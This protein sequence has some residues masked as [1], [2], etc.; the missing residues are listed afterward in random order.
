MIN[1]KNTNSDYFKEKDEYEDDE[2]ISIIENM[3]CD[4]HVKDERIEELEERIK[5]LTNPDEPDRYEDYRLGLI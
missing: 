2:I 1:F 5:Q 4:M 3:E